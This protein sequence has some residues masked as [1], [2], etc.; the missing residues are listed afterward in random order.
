MD[1]HDVEPEP[2]REAFVLVSVSTAGGSPGLR[3]AVWRKL[4]SLGALYLQQSVCLLPDRELVR[5]EVRRLLARVRS[6]GGTG[7]ALRV[8][9]PDPAEYAEV[10]AEFNAARDEEYAEVLQRAPA[11]LEEIA[12]ETER[13][14]ATYA[15]VEESEADLDRFR[16]WLSKIEARD[17][18]DAPGRTAAQ[19]AVTR[20]ATALAEFENAAL[21][22][23]AGESVTATTNAAT[24]AGTDTP[25]RPAPADHRPQHHT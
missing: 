6:D 14:R 20:C 23:E 8:A 16:T 7:R 17:Y 11:L 13:G 4:R 18:F 9:L 19:A 12:T 25:S 22:A 2:A 21:R 24:N 10:V 1:E 5:R 15:E 3:M